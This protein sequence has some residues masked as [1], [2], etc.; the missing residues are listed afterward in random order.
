MWN[1]HLLKIHLIFR[2][3]HSRREPLLIS[4]WS[5]YVPWCVP[6]S[7]QPQHLLHKIVASDN[8]V[9]GVAQFSSFIHAVVWSCQFP[10]QARPFVTIRKGRRYTF[11]DPET[12]LRGHAYYGL[13]RWKQNVYLRIR[14]AGREEGEFL[15]C[16]TSEIQY[17]QSI[18]CPPARWNP[19]TAELHYNHYS[20]VKRRSPSDT[21]HMSSEFNRSPPTTL[22]PLA[23]E[24]HCEIQKRI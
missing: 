18:K 11:A 19:A 23:V 10:H 2:S 4:E 21:F 8:Y 6:G 15:P 16:E 1:P 9:E 7:I 17:R 24:I 22:L 13:R 12:Y 3:Y 5:N 14:F 20:E